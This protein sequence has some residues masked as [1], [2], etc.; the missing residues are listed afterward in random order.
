[1][2]SPGSLSNN[3]KIINHEFKIG[4]RYGGNVNG[5][6]FLVTDVLQPG[7]RIYSTPNVYKTVKD[8][9]VCFQD[10]KTKKIH[11]VSLETAKRLLMTRVD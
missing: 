3:M 10:Q 11:R 4:Q 7:T 8:P 6:E 1:M 9:Y 2:R 5:V